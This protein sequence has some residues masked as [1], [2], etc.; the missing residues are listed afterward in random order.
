M[1]V[2][3]SFC[4]GKDQGIC[5]RKRKGRV[6]VQKS[7][8]SKNGIK[9]YNKTRMQHNDTLCCILAYTIYIDSCSKYFRA[10][11]IF[12]QKNFLLPLLR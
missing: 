3:C 6:A 8:L 10:I 9:L 2:I 1:W 12:F 11:F 7:V 4:C 5:R